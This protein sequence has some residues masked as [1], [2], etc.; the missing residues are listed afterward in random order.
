MGRRLGNGVSQCKRTRFAQG[1]KLPN[2][3]RLCYSCFLDTGVQARLQAL[4][5]SS[6]EALSGCSRTLRWCSFLFYGRSLQTFPGTC[7][8]TAPP[9]LYRVVR[10]QENLESKTQVATCLSPSHVLVTR[11][12]TKVLLRQV[13][14]KRTANIAFAP[15]FF[16]SSSFAEGGVSPLSRSLWPVVYLSLFL[17]V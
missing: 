3:L 14:M 7:G 11:P 4:T 5:C 1:N 17:L 15:F 2:V 10:G 13:E 8:D 16:S 12:S 9:S 6:K